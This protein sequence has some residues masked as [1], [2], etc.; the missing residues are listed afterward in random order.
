MLHG[1]YKIVHND[2]KTVCMTGIIYNSVIVGELYPIELIL[3]LNE[4]RINLFF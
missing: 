3:R 4:I 2:K 1:K